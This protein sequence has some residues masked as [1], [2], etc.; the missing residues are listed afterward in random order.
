MKDLN[1]FVRFFLLYL[2][3]SR[4]FSFVKGFLKNFFAFLQIFFDNHALSLI[5]K[6]V[7][8]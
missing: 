5:F 3:Y 8:N 7:L 1:I 4:E 2:Y 6:G